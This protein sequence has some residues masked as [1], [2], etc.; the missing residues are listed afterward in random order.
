MTP[1]E[2]HYI[3]PLG[4]HWLTP[5]YDWLAK[6]FGANFRRRLIEQANIQPGQRVLDLG[7]GT[8]IMAIALKGSMPGAQVTGLDADK[9]AL[10]IARREAEKA[11]A[12]IEWDQGFANDLA[13][14]DNSLDV[15]VSSFM[16][17][18]LTATD[19]LRTFREVRRVL[20]PQ[21]GFY[22]LDFGPPFSLLTR[23]QA[24]VMKNLERTAD[25][26]KGRLLPMLEE[27]SFGS[28]REVGHGNTLFG[29]IAIYVANR[30]GG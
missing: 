9:K 26:F 25:N 15:V 20:R 22:I 12:K 7:C 19:K 5:F 27:A 14:A 10:T 6:P 24:A 16:I 11:G 1:R 21:G 18:H 4:F 8:G 29:P 28:A 2:L 13:Y 3:P 30:S 23:V 17:H